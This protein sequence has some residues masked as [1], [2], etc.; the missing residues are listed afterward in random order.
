MPEKKT[1]LANVSGRITRT[2]RVHYI[3]HLFRVPLG[4]AKVGLVFSFHK[5][6]LAQYFISLHDPKGFRGSTMDPSTVGDVVLDL[7][8]GANDSSEGGVAGGIV[9]GEWRV[10]IDVERTVED[11]DY[12]LLVY[13]VSGSAGGIYCP[14]IPEDRPIKTDPGWYGGELHCHS[15]ESDGKYSVENVVGEASRLG[16]DFLALTDH[17]T[18]S[19]WR[20]LDGLAYPRSIALLHSCEITSHQGHANL[21]GISKWVDVYVDREGWSM[22]QAAD[23]THGQG[24]LF[25]VNHMYSGDLR[26]QDFSFDWHKADLIEIYHNLEGCNNGPMLSWWDHLLSQGL[27]I[28]GV[29]G[30]DSHDPFTGRHKLGQCVSWVYADELSERGIISGIKRG[31]VV[32]SNGAKLRFSA[33][34]G[35]R[36]NVKMWETAECEDSPVKF[37]IEAS[38]EEPMRL[39]IIKNGLILDHMALN[40]KDGEWKKVVYEDKPTTTS[41]YRVELHKDAGTNMDPR[42]P[43][44]F[45]RD[46]SSMLALS[47][48][49]WVKVGR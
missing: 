41:F 40:N 34:D 2:P 5:K 24:G 18:I 44:I 4:T 30:T 32:V 7:W 42:Y 6:Q 47:N 8:V 9:P 31:Q 39:F 35:H 48:P 36:G 12:H 22:N 21:H 15:T 20:K 29:G 11:T 13:A 43:G 25:C 45:W 16:L 19:Q 49:I 1:I 23:A 37:T 10:Q 27:K 26:W 46:Y 14:K 38:S 33:E 28:V 3:N 17:F